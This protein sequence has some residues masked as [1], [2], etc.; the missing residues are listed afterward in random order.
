MLYRTTDVAF[1]TF[2]FPCLVKLVG[3]PILK[4][5]N[6]F[7]KPN[8]AWSIVACGPKW[9]SKV[10]IVSESHKTGN[11]TSSSENPMELPVPPRTDVGEIYHNSPL[12]V[13]IFNK[14]HHA[15]RTIL[16]CLPKLPAPGSIKTEEASIKAEEQAKTASKTL[17]FRDVPGRESALCLAVRLNDAKAVE[18]LMIAGSDVNLQVNLKNFQLSQAMS[19]EVTYYVFFSR[20]LLDGPLFKKLFIRETKC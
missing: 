20:T 14:D 9:Y 16:E 7:Q 12:H 11:V 2:S 5:G 6:V 3:L 10:H 15:L 1:W 17:D 18:M 13:A 8:F 19:G 4:V